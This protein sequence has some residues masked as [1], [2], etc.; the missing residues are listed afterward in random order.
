MALSPSERG[1]IPDE[2]DALREVEVGFGGNLTGDIGGELIGDLIPDSSD[3]RPHNMT[4]ESRD[5]AN[6][7]IEQQVC[8]RNPT[9]GLEFLEMLPDL[10]H[11][12]KQ[13]RQV[14]ARRVS[15]SKPYPLASRD[16]DPPVPVKI[17]STLPATPLNPQAKTAS[18]AA[19]KK[20]PSWMR[21][22][23][24]QPGLTRKHS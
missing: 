8:E 11:L 5:S 18:L 10:T 1:I 20:L 13:H 16:T 22:P 23:A 7:L 6:P 19:R 17:R 21:A 3:Q 9:A 2:A 12:R 14:Q 24:A 15:K 4:V